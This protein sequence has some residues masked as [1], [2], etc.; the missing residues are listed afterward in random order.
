MSELKYARILQAVTATPW[1]ILPEKMA[2]IRDLLAFRA[3]GGQLTPEEVKARVEAGRSTSVH[4]HQSGGGVAVI[5][6][7]GSIIPRANVMTESSGAVSVQRFTSLFREA[8]S[9]EDIGSIVIDIDSPGGQVGGVAELAA[10][11][12]NAR[13]QKPV[14]AVANTLAASAAYWIG[15]AADELVVTPSGQVGSIGVFAMHEDISAML[16]REGVKINLISAG[17]YK[18]E[19]NPF[20]PLT[21][22]ARAN[23]QTQIDTYYD[24][25]VTA[26]ARGRG[27]SVDAVRNGFGQGRTVGAD[28]AVRLGMADR[29]ATLDETIRQRQ[30]G[31]K[32]K[33][34]HAAD[35]DFRRRRLRLNEN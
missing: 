27:V 35:L 5:P 33:R 13:G 26:V 17:K 3:A 4:R 15:S 32:P 10:E 19:G 12:Y 23:M 7:V 30:Q 9:N 20:E 28:E 8:L 1:A 24:M 21:D 14:T 2:V 25:F 34:R 6:L 22:E 16:E 31:G 18:V 11:I 29:V